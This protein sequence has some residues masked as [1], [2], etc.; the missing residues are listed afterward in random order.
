M[1]STGDFRNLV[2]C[3]TLILIGTIIAL[4]NGAMPDPED[5]NSPE[6]W[7]SVGNMHF[8]GKNYAGA[9]NCYYKALQ[10]NAGFAPAWHNL[11]L[12]YLRLGDR[13]RANLCFDQEEKITGE[14]VPRIP[15]HS[16]K[17]KGMFRPRS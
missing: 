4:Q 12:C 1:E 11:G 3:H 15:E 6:Y 7:K 10:L 16:Q 2:I 14:P 9:A 17:K 8:V 5:E 13:E